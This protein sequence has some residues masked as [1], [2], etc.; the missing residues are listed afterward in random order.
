[1]YNYRYQSHGRHNILI[2]FPKFKK[3]KIALEIKWCPELFQLILGYTLCKVCMGRFADVL[4]ETQHRQAG[5]N[6]NN[7]N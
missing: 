1:M 2:T 6:L 7:R 4:L 3:N 5:I